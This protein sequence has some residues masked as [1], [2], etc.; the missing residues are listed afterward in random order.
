MGTKILSQPFTHFVADRPRGALRQRS[1][2]VWALLRS[3]HFVAHFVAGLNHRKYKYLEEWSEWQD[4]NLRPL[5]P[6]PSYRAVS[7]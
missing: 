1:L 5:R 6:E 2:A 4:L 7:R 3:S